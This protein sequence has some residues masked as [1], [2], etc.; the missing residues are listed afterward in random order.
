MMKR[1]SGRFRVRARGPVA[2]FTR[3]EMK[4]ERVSYEV[5][6]PSAARGLLEAV[7]WKPSIRWHVHEIAVLAPIQWTSFRRNEVGSRASPKVR[8]FYVEE[9][10]AQRNTVALRDV[11]YVITCS[12]ELTGRAGP[13]ENVRKFE[14][15]FERRLGRG[16]SF[17]Q[18]Y[19]GCREFVADVEPAP[20]E[21]RPIQPEV[22]RPLGLM[23][24]DFDYGPRGEISVRPLFFEARL[25]GGVLHVPPRNEVLHANGGNP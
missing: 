13:E 12:F 19:L 21:L 24:Y 25:K 14:E 22:D 7:L 18:P 3:P 23:F 20:S 11:D 5:M 6:T 10:R 17:H 8:D 15:M 9:R 2:C 4:A 16:Q 1:E